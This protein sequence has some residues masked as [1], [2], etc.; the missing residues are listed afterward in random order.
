M[1]ISDF[2]APEDVIVDLRVQQKRQL[3]GELGERAAVRLGSPREEIVTAL[4]NRESLGSTGMGSGI[5]IPH[6]RIDAAAKPLGVMAR[7]QRPIA[8]DA[9]DDA[10]VDLVFLLLLPKSD[11]ADSLAALAL[12][13]RKLRSAGDVARM[14]R[15][16]DTVDLYN[17]LVD[18]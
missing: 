12:V 10:P 18:H 16:H 13:S 6:A 4:L 7:L 11:N 1:K 9:I 3:I 14:R 17:I 2:L 5:A 8:F 15:A